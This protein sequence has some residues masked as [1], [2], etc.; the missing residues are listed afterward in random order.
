MTINR[1]IIHLYLFY[2]AV[3]LM[4]TGFLVSRSLLTAGTSVMIAN[5]FLQ[6]DYSERW[7]AFKKNKVVV[8]I[9]CLFFFP[10]LSGLWSSNQPLWFDAVWDKLPLL[11][12]PFA[13][14]LQ[15]GFERKQ[16]AAAVLLWMALMF[17]GSIWSASFYF[18]NQ[19]HYNELYR[20]SKTIPTPAENDHI[21]FSMAIIIA[22]LFWMKLEEWKAISSTLLRWIFRVM[23]LWLLL[24]LH[25]LG[26]KTGL[27]G[28]YFIL[29][30]LLIW[31][32]VRAN[33]KQ[34]AT[35]ALLLAVA[36]PVVAYYSVPTFRNRLHYIVF[37]KQNWNSEQFAGNFSDGNRWQSIRSGWYVF[38]NN[39]LAGVGYGDIREEA[40]KWYATEA[41][42]VASSQQFLPLNQWL[43]S[44]SGA[45]I[46][47][48]ILFTVVLILPFFQKEW[49]QNKQALL[50]L[51]FM[52]ILFLYE[53][54][55]DDQFGVFL[56]CFFT[57]LWI[58]AIRHSK[59]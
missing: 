59:Y 43:T 7:N 26:A 5:G 42:A 45:G 52:D 17:A 53:C 50:F 15:K 11:L 39:W 57:L 49:R 55:L 6:N 56:F 34:L 37:E 29:F 10:F 14:L 44:G 9:T 2:T 33:K 1:P 3:V 38:K 46:G 41:P 20:F 24:Y 4:M 35:A 32:L 16:I 8:G 31:Q 25:L 19:E 13:M 36:L 58:L 18:G 22:L 23:A 40:A 51:F 28:I 21:R 30:P 27:L 12:L 48:V 54:T 47:A